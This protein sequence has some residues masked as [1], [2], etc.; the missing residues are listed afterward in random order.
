MSLCGIRRQRARGRRI[1]LLNTT[2]PGNGGRIGFYIRDPEI[3]PPI[4]KTGVWRFGPD[5]RPVEQFERAEDCR[6]VY[7]GQFLSMCLHG[8]NVGFEPRR[9]LATGGASV[10]GSVIRVMS[11]VF[12][13]PVYVAE[14]SDSASLGAAYRALHGWKCAQTG[15]WVPFGDVLQGAEPFK[16]VADPD[17]Q[18]HAVYTAMLE[19][20]ATLE[21]QIMNP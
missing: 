21:K 8:R 19:R 6:A 16:K 14:K 13:T 10:D 5:G 20:Y 15:E 17:M 2:A 12:G 18:A 7:E 4:L 9:L 3:T 11:D 1:A